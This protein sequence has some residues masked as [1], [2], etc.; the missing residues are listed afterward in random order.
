M[1]EYQNEFYSTSDLSTRLKIRSGGAL[2]TI[3]CDVPSPLAPG[4]D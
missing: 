1:H 2:V 3:I 4:Q